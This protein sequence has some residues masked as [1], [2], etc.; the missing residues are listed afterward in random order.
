MY[1]NIINSK[2]DDPRY[3]IKKDLNGEYVVRDSGKDYGSERYNNTIIRSKG[4]LK[5]F[6]NAIEKERL[7]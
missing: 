2:F 4:Y 3:D 5:R 7:E 1:L 6:Y